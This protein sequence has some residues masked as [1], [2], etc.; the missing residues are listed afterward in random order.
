MYKRVHE[1]GLS[2]SLQRLNYNLKWK[3]VKFSL[4][5]LV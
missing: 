4:F 1:I 2:I 5:F 3:E